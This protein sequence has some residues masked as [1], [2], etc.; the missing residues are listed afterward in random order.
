MKNILEK[1]KQSLLNKGKDKLVDK[2]SDLLSG[3]SKK[4]TTKIKNETKDKIKG[5][6]GG[7]FEKKKKNN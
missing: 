5:I 1:Q 6:L 4:D 2:L 7:L 3:G